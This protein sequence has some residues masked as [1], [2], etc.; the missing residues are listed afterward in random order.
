MKHLLELFPKAKTSSRW[1]MN[2]KWLRKYG[3]DEEIIYFIRYKKQYRGENMSRKTTSIPI[4]SL[5]NL[6]KGLSEEAKEEIFEKVFIEED[7]TPLT[8]EER[9]AVI[10][11]EEEIKTG[12][13]IRW[14]FGK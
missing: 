13:T 4:E 7:I 5:I 1:K 12:E 10:K 3:D 8:N 14:P 2:K 9:E 11:A 6:L